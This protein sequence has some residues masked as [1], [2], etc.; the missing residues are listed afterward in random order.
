MAQK[1]KAVANKPDHMSSIPRYR[2][3][4]DSYK[5]S[6]DI[7]VCRMAMMVCMNPHIQNK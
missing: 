7:H 2:K 1:I 4:T 3:R 6:F 5:L